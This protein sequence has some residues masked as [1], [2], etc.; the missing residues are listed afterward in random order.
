[1][2]NYYKIIYGHSLQDM[3]TIIAFTVNYL[4]SL[5]SYIDR[6]GASLFVRL[7]VWVSVRWIHFK[8]LF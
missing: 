8:K 6:L 4:I 7:L 5:K 1:M 3:T 2:Y